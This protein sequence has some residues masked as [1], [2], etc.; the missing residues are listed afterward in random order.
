VRNS[1]V[2]SRIRNWC[3][4]VCA[5]NL[6]EE[7]ATLHLDNDNNT[8]SEYHKNSMF[9]TFNTRHCLEFNSNV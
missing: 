2:Y 6:V 5:S 3:S 8:E 7:H 4:L 1:D 9:Q